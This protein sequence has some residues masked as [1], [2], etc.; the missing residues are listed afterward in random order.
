MSSSENNNE[1]KAVENNT[2]ESMDF[3]EFLTTEREDDT[4]FGRFLARTN[5]RSFQ[6]LEFAQNVIS[7][8]MVLL[9]WVSDHLF[10]IS[11]G[12]IAIFF[13]ITYMSQKLAL[14]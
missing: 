13:V 10:I 14:F 3:I 8:I 12:F 7:F 1:N 11:F 9:R 2:E 4:D 6:F 5:K